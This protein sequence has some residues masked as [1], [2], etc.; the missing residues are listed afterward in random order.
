MLLH[1]ITV[2]IKILVQNLLHLSEALKQ[3]LHFNGIIKQFYMQK[4]VFSAVESFIF[5]VSLPNFVFIYFYNRV[6]SD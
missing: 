3:M 2:L 1:T 5:Y 4:N 6:R